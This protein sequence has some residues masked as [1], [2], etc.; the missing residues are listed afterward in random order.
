M[1]GVGVVGRRFEA[2]FR[3]LAAASKYS[4]KGCSK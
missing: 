3:V 1:D 2:L 4:S